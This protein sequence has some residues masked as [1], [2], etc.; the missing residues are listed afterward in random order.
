MS[1]ESKDCLIIRAFPPGDDLW[2]IDW[3]GEIKFPD[4]LTRNRQPSVCVHLSPV[5]TVAPIHL[6]TSCWVSV[7]TLILLRIGDL[8][9]NQRYVASS[10][11]RVT[12]FADLTIAPDPDFIRAGTSEGGHFLLPLAR[13]P[14]H[15]GSTR[16]F[17]V[18]LRLS[19]G[20]Q[21][22]IPCMELVRFY[23]GSSST[24][25]AKLCRP[26]LRR[27]DLY[28]PE[29]SFVSPDKP[30]SHITLAPELPGRS[31]ADVARIAGNREAW[32]CAVRIGASIANPYSQGHVRTGFPFSGT[33]TLEV[34]GVWLPLGDA[35]GKTF[36]VHELL[37]C[38]HP[39][40]FQRLSYR[41]AEGERA[42]Q[43]GAS[44]S[45]TWPRRGQGA[46][47]ASRS[48][49]DAL[50]E[51]DAGPFAGRTFAVPEAL[52]FTDLE[53]KPLFR[54]RGKAT[55]E[56]TPIKGSAAIQKLALGESGSS[57]RIRPA[58]VVLEHERPI[59]EFLQRVVEVIR[60]RRHVHFE[61]LTDSGEDGWTLP[62]KSLSDAVPTS[63]GDYLDPATNEVRPRRAAVFVL[64][65]DDWVIACIVIEHET[66]VS[67]FFDVSDIEAA[68]GTSYC[69]HL[70]TLALPQLLEAVGLKAVR[71]VLG[72]DLRKR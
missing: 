14:W 19:E 30:H 49:N 38:T 54:S 71:A 46:A 43:S 58:E 18:R 12:T 61:V 35:P 57:H 37:R 70:V 56:A 21:L 60:Q 25:L 16:S 11:P 65:H 52:R 59:P 39:L 24:L 63:L 50:V 9:R 15:G 1:Q 7:G 55:D 72:N 66:L 8:W 4:R 45:N 62:L 6:Q 33:T 17:C 10:P 20:R 32:R 67:A 69:S 2:R 34:K 53:H 3:F 23:F 51:Q 13:H 42:T 26:E 68:D 22:I 40:P 27:L 47:A 36:V 64:Y 29:K 28:N 48:R 31:A 44:T 5:E 41:T